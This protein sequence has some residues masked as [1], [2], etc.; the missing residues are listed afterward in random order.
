MWLGTCAQVM[1]CMENVIAGRPRWGMVFFHSDWFSATRTDVVR[2]IRY[3]TFITEHLSDCDYYPRVRQRWA[4][5][6]HGT[7]CPGS[8]VQV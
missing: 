4:T 6:N 1:A 8:K 3:D 2:E 7:C 5:F